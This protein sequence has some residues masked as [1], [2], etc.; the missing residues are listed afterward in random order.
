MAISIVAAVATNRVIGNNGK[1]PWHL[2]DDL[3]R[4]KELTVGHSVVMGRKTWESIG[5]PLPDR[6]NYVLTRHKDLQ[7]PGVTVIT[8]LADLFKA[9]GNNT[10]FVIGGAD[11][12][13]LFLPIADRMYL[14]HVHA[15][16]DGDVLFPQVEWPKWRSVS[17]EQGFVDADNDHECSYEIYMRFPRERA[18][19]PVV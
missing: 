16:P 11:V 13:R 17:W 10:L 12:Y 14:T 18:G 19:L 4:F 7:I 2:G 9:V 6:A 3:R 15:T 8:E 1:I 5:R